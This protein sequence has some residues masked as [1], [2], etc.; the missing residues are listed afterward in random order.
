MDVLK[1]IGR[2]AELGGI[3]LLRVLPHRTCR[4]VGPFVFIDHFGPVEPTHMQVAPHP[5]IGLHTLTWLFSGEI[6]HR[7]SIGTEQPIRAGELNW[8]TAGSG[9]THSERTPPDRPQPLHGLQCWVA[10]SVE[11]EQDP[12]EFQ[13][14]PADALPTFSRDGIQWKVVV[15]HWL[16]EHS[17]LRINWPTFFV[18]G[19]T[20]ASDEWDWPYPGIWSCGI[21]VVEGRMTVSFGGRTEVVAAGE[22]LVIPPVRGLPQPNVSADAGVRFVCLGGE[23]FPED[24][25]FDWNFVASDR[26]LLAAARADWIAQRRFPPVPGDSERI[27]HPEEHSKS[28][29]S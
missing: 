5:H 2:S 25:H 26:A 18:E 23:P 1:V 17:P 11:H 19:L 29:H 10:Q 21:Y 14:L 15:G 24:R 3:P 7:D 28:E 16:E 13:H 6:M 27:P 8:M 12:A 4:A 22:L 20:E 9:V